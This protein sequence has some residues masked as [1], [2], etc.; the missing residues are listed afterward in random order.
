MSG[1]LLS[2]KAAQE[3]RNPLLEEEYEEACDVEGASGAQSTRH[4]V[5][6]SISVILLLCVTSYC[7]YYLT[8]KHYTH[9]LGSFDRG[10][11]TE[12]G[13]AAR[14]LD[15][16]TQ[17]LYG[18]AHFD[19]QGRMYMADDSPAMKYAGTGED[20]DLA[21]DAALLRWGHW[22]LVTDEEAKEAWGERYVDYWDDKSGGYAAT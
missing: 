3:Q 18:N 14:L 9:P 11:A 13:P 21:W 22:F 15:V 4:Y 6:A 7:T 1:S 12:F 19:E 20:T 16:Q 2:Q 17:K 10:F 5:V 8:A